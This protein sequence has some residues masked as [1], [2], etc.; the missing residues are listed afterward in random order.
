MRGSVCTSQAD[1][2]VVK[3]LLQAADDVY[4]VNL[5]KLDLLITLSMMTDE[6]CNKYNFNEWRS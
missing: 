5:F 4:E 3:L 2:D 1:D 6:I